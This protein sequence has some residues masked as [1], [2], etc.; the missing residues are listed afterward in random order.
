M[1]ESQQ[2]FGRADDEGNVYLITDGEERWVGQFPGQSPAE[3]LAFYERK[4]RDLAGQLTLLEQRARRGAKAKDLKKSVTTLTEALVEPAVIGDVPALRARLDAVK[5]QLGD[6][7]QQQ[8]EQ[9]SQAVE[10]AARDREAIVVEIEQLAATPAERIRWKDTQAQVQA[11]FDRWKEHQR[12]AA[13][14]PKAQADALWA[15]FRAA[16][17]TLDEGRRAFFSHLDEQH[18]GAKATKQRLIEQAEALAAQD[19]PRVNDYR[20]LLDQWKA[21]GR[22]GGKTDDR[23]WEQ[24]KAAGDVVFAKKQQHDAVEDEQFQKNLEVKEQ[25]LVKAEALLPVTDW[26]AARASLRRIQDEWDAAGKVPRNAIKTVEGRLRA[27]E[28]A[29]KRAEQEHWRASDTTLTERATGLAAQLQE[30]IADLEAQIAAAQ[31]AGD[32]AKV[33]ELTSALHTQQAWL[34]ATGV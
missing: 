16:R 19:E 13:R 2:Q 31:A 18:K 5:T 3:A 25:L 6:L 10:Q 30:S 4:Y 9:A 23:L 11:L 28:E 1:S 14:I 26:E 22:A 24:F 32:T 29:V 27:V 34:R 33:E 12:T 17:H 15:R 21:A 8:S 7:E 20:A